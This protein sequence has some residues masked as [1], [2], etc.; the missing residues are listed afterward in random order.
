[1]TS[2]PSKIWKL[3]VCANQVKAF[4][5]D[6]VYLVPQDLK[7]LLPRIFPY[8]LVLPLNEDVLDRLHS[9]KVHEISDVFLD[10]NRV[11]SNRDGADGRV[12]IPLDGLLLRDQL[13]DMFLLIPIL[14]RTHEKTRSKRRK[15]RN[16]AYLLANMHRRGNHVTRKGRTRTIISMKK[17]EP[18]LTFFNDF[19]VMMTP[20]GPKQPVCLMCPCHL[21]HVQGKCSLGE[22]KC[23]ESLILKP[24]REKP[25]E[26]LQED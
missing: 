18:F 26:Q 12:G 19:A 17:D 21:E 23:Y 9:I 15:D 2:T 1:M 25:R 4:P 14:P 16:P 20:R 10:K 22:Q 13:H 7:H 24:Q 5:F 8:S 6:V 3:K 11:P